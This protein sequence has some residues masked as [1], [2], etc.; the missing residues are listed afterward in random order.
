MNLKTQSRFSVSPA[1]TDRK[2][3]SPLS[4]SQFSK[5]KNNQQ[6]KLFDQ[7]LTSKRNLPKISS[8]E[9]SGIGSWNNTP[10]VVGNSARI[11]KGVNKETQLKK[12]KKYAMKL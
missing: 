10:Q 9:L 7:P 11:Y 5:E 4:Q 3:F 8:R 6:S 2:I 1:P 12:L